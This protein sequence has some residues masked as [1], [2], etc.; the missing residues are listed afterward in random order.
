MLLDN[1]PDILVSQY[2]LSHKN[3]IFVEINFNN[4]WIFESDK[5]YCQMKCKEEH[6]IQSYSKYWEL[7]NRRSFAS[8]KDTFSLPEYTK[9]LTTVNK[10]INRSQKIKE[11]KRRKKE[12]NKAKND[13]NNISLIQVS[14]TVIKINLDKLPNEELKVPTSISTRRRNNMKPSGIQNIGNTCYLS[15]SI[16]CLKHTTALTDYFAKNEF[17]FSENSSNLIIAEFAKLI[18]AL[19]INGTCVTPS[20]FKKCLDKNTSQFPLNKQ[21]DAHEF[22]SFLI[23]KLHD[24]TSKIGSLDIDKLFYG[25]FSS[26]IQCTDCHNTSITNEPF[27]CISLPID[28]TIEN[29]PLLLQ[30]N[31]QG[32]INLCCRIDDEGITIKEIKDQI[33]K[34]L[35]IN[36][37][38]FYVFSNNEVK[39][40]NNTV[41]VDQILGLGKSW[42]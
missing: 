41:S 28:G 16:Q 14:G 19:K 21:C 15:S 40:I 6:D 42:T 7:I 11:G 23:D 1:Y 2:E 33:R 35:T 36:E 3:T 37:I 31:S 10:S 29:I 13:T 12:L 20:K 38:D 9:I 32:L 34:L 26:S 25:R 17:G 18:S 4:G 39:E 30:T 24:E 5:T 22:L 27:M 8:I